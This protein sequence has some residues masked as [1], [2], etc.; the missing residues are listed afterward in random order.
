MDD[1]GLLSGRPDGDGRLAVSP[2]R[3]AL[4]G[5][6]GYAVLLVALAV[7]AA[8][9]VGLALLLLTGKGAWVAVKLGAIVL[10][11]FWIILRAL[12]VK[13]PAPNGLPIDEADAPR[14]FALVE[15]VRRA[16]VAPPIDTI[17]FTEDLNAGVAHV[18]WL[19]LFGPGRT[20]LLLG[21]PLMQGLTEAQLGAVL[22][23]EFGHVSGKHTRFG[24]WVYR[25]RLTWAR[26]AA[27]LE[28]SGAA[29]PLRAFVR[30]YFPR[31]AG[32]SLVVARAQEIQADRDSAEFAG[33][34]T[35][36]D[37]LIVTQLQGRLLGERLWSEL[38]RRNARLSDPPPAL[39]AETRSLLVG[40]LAPE[41]ASR[42]VRHALAETADPNDTHPPLAERL[43]HL[44]QA[45]RVPPSGMPASQTLLGDFEPRL[46]E[47]L[48]RW[49]SEQATEGWKLRHQSLETPRRRLA[50][51]EATLATG[52]LGI[53]EG[54]QRADLVEDFRGEAEAL[55]LFEEVLARAPDHARAHL[56]VG[57]ILTLRDDARALAHLERAAQVDRRL[58]G[59]ACEL[60]ALYWSR[61]GRPEEVA[62]FR[63]RLAAWARVAEEARAERQRV[64]AGDLL[65]PHGLEATAVAR[66]AEQLARFP[67]V[68]EAWLVQK[69]L[70]HFPEHP[71]YVLGILAGDSWRSRDVAAA[72]R[73]LG[74]LAAGV[75]LPGEALVVDVRL[76][77]LVGNRLREAE[78]AQVYR[79]AS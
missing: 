10:P 78:G 48:G 42:W 7:L 79:R 54:W 39:F 21:L 68:R 71:L 35:A 51:L 61:Q 57:R 25:A 58:E 2:L 36:A 34:R 1:A 27:Q 72:G 77:K 74:T 9:C 55:P 20:Y 41:L 49:W 37:A 69:V 50:E 12:W 30:W 75:S 46:E 3:V 40:G 64:H 22:A 23:H 43:R 67:E 70:R 56:S 4:L 76:E 24:A 16:L 14:L 38:A 53:D 63:A 8:A 52:A 59:A 31:F 33:A 73:L 11:L 18:P 62:G 26:L 66:L 15:R 28:G 47:A 19:G 60:L 65:A 29:A 13:I 6:L 32:A 44:G 45:E 5:A 17:L